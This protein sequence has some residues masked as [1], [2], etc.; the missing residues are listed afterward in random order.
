MTSSLYDSVPMAMPQEAL[1][2]AIPVLVVSIISLAASVMLFL[3]HFYHSER[4]SCTFFTSCQRSKHLPGVSILTVAVDVSLMAISVSCSTSASICQQFW[5]MTHWRHDRISEY[6]QAKLG[7]ENPTL[8][9][10]PLTL[11]PSLVLFWIQVY[12]YNV[13]S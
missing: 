8:A 11:G 5:Y 1:V 13:L 12:F 10:G 2:V 3:M 4:W 7:V 9:I 6:Q